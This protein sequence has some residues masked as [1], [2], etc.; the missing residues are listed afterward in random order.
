MLRLCLVNSKATSNNHH[1]LL[2]SLQVSSY[3]LLPSVQLSG[4]PHLRYVLAL[5]LKTIVHSHLAEV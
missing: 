4:L 1:M 5:L 2:G 3:E